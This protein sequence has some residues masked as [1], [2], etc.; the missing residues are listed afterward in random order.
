MNEPR[1]VIHDALVGLATAQGVEVNVYDSPAAKIAVPALVVRPDTPWRTPGTFRKSAENYAVVAVVQAGDPAS[2]IDQLRRLARLVEG[3]QD[4]ASWRWV[5]TSGV[6][7]VAQDGI[8][9]LGVTIK[10]TGAED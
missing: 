5:E 10:I 4:V 9:Y 7:Q 8:D 2:A 3:V 1:I 6:A